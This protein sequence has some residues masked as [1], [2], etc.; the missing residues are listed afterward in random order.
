M[1][2]KVVAV[3]G[4]YRPGH[5]VD[6]T[7]D[8]VLEG[9]REAGA[10]VSKID[11]LDRHIEFCTNCRDCAQQPGSPRGRCHIKDDMAAILDEIDAADAIV[12]ASPMNFGT[13]TAVMKRFME[14]LMVYGHWPWEQM[15]PKGRI[16]KPSKKALVVTASAMP[17]V[18]GRF[19]TAILPVMKH[20]TRV[21]GAR[22][23]STL[24]FG[25]ACTSRDQRLTPDQKAKAAAA[26]RKLA[27]S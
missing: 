11:L 8:A 27:A 9:A 7:V 26:G 21:V 22:S 14:R 16:E 18:V 17:A 12:L 20:A 2:R 5:I 1:S 4:T 23:T 10:Q 15:A 6:C 24:Y 25:M 3:V 19:K 13:V